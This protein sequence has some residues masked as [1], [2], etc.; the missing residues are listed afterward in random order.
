MLL[1]ANTPKSMASKP[2]DANLVVHGW[3]S[4]VVLL[5]RLRGRK[6]TSIG[7]D[8]IDPLFTLCQKN[9]LQFMAFPVDLQFEGEVN[10]EPHFGRKNDWELMAAEPWKSGVKQLILFPSLGDSTC[11]ELGLRTLAHRI[12]SSGEALE[13]DDSFVNSSW[14][15]QDIK[16]KLGQR[17]RDVL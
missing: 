9:N 16:T 8:E 17:K 3:G 4:V 14:A 2:V 11:Q 5:Q 7:K 13:F 15:S 12:L 6:S 10:G 1:D